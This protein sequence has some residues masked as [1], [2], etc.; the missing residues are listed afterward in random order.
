MHPN[1]ER[2]G[3]N[4]LGV[5][6]HLTSNISSYSYSGRMKSHQIKSHDAH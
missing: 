3:C 6:T 5:A 1:A 4:K 2:K